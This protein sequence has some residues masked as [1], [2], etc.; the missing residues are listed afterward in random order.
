MIFP[1]RYGLEAIT[2]VPGWLERLTD[3]KYCIERESQ[4][5]KLNFIMALRRNPAL[6]VHM[7]LLLWFNLLLDSANDKERLSDNVAI[8]FVLQRRHQAQIFVDNK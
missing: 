6:E 3:R 8:N 4:Q 5:Q 7:L 2:R 1:G